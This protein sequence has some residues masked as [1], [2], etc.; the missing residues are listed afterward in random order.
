MESGK[1]IRNQQF[2]RMLGRKTII[3]DIIKHYKETNENK[4]R[5]DII[6]QRISAL[7][8]GITYF[9]MGL[10][11]FCPTHSFLGKKSL[12]S[13]IHLNPFN[14][15]SRLCLKFLPCD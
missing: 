3:D 10:D 13:Q 1:N 9:G 8:Y 5:E 12:L 14:N 2:I 15:I 4:K 7:F 6:D 11:L